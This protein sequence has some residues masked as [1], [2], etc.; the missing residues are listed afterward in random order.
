MW[1][2]VLDTG[3]GE[4]GWNPAG[5][6]PVSKPSLQTGDKNPT[7]RSQEPPIAWLVLSS[8]V[9]EVAASKRAAQIVFCLLSLPALCLVYHWSQGAVL[10]FAFCR[11][12]GTKNET[13]EV[14]K[15]RGGG[16]LTAKGLSSA[17][18]A[19]LILSCVLSSETG[20][21]LLITESKRSAR[22][23]STLF[24]ER[25]GVHVYGKAFRIRE[26]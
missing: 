15:R 26:F 8:R 16:D 7:P 11:D 25:S 18:V 13:H 19:Q 10:F 5:G 24:L 4:G 21:S 2:R 12:R 3:N 22:V 6:V 17:G 23:F 1:K 14:T 20:L 9:R